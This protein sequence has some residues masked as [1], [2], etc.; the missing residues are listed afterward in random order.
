MGKSVLVP[1]D[2]GEVESTWPHIEEFVERGLAGAQGNY[3]PID[4]KNSCINRDMQLWVSINDTVFEACLITQIIVYPRIKVAGLIVIG[5]S[6]M[7][8]WLKY[9]ATI[10][11]WAKSQ[12][13]EE[14]EGYARKGWLRVLTGWKPCWTLIRKEL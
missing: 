5:G 7:K 4:I 10:A 12:G 8:N 14:L 3:W 6:G 9:E 13:C 11:A 1:V 2:S